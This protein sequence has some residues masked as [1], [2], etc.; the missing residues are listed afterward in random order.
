MSNIVK[1]GMIFDESNVPDFGNIVIDKNG[2]FALLQ[3]DLPKLLTNVTRN[4]CGSAFNV[5][6][7]QNAIVVDTGEVLIYHSDDI[8]HYIKRGF[9]KEKRYGRLSLIVENNGSAYIL[10][11]DEK[12][13]FNIMDGNNI[14]IS[15]NLT[16]IHYCGNGVYSYL[17]NMEDAGILHQLGNYTINIKVYRGDNDITSTLTI[18]YTDAE[19][20]YDVHI[21]YD[22]GL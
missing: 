10:D 16:L 17:L 2:D 21:I 6:V 19:E 5:S 11:D 22:T 12:I 3:T 9:I 20:W 13:V 1:L 14:A 4:I 15:K 18:E 7:G 8:W